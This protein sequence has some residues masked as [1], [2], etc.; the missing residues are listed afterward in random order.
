M[1]YLSKPEATS[2]MAKAIE[3]VESKEFK[4]N[5]VDP[6]QIEMRGKGARTTDDLKKMIDNGEINLDEKAKE[7]VLG[8]CNT[9]S[10]GK[11]NK[12]YPTIATSIATATNKEVI[13]SSKSTSPVHHTTQRNGKWNKVSADGTK[14]TPIGGGTKLDLTTKKVTP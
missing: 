14:A 7:I 6:Y 4:T 12:A 1:E 10:V 2:D 11:E 5:V 9:V 8:G 13:G 3:F